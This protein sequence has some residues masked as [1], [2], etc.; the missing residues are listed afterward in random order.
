VV[1]PMSGVFTARAT[2]LGVTVAAA[3]A[4]RVATWRRAT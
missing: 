2:A 4:R 3:A 1:D